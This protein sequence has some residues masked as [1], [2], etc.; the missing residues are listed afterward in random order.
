MDELDNDFHDLKKVV[1]ELTATAE[2]AADRN[3]LIKLKQTT[4]DELRARPELIWRIIDEFQSHP[5]NENQ[6]FGVVLNVMTT[7]RSSTIMISRRII[8][9]MLKEAEIRRKTC[10]Q[11]NY[12]KLQ[13][14][15][16]AFA[17][18]VRKPEFGKR[19]RLA[20]AVELVH[21]V[22][23]KAL[24]EVAG[25]E[26]D[27]VEQKQAYLDGMADALFTRQQNE[28]SEDNDEYE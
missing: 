9:A 10:D 17:I 8:N 15:L 27:L 5:K 13:D 23:R 16:E 6:I 21:P 19:G 26:A 2:M 28:N 11:Q 18:W 1:A 25:G 12:R 20:G 7:S 24:A 3:T 22:I 4:T 14:L